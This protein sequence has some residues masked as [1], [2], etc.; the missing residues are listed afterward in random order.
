MKSTLLVRDVMTIGVPIC[1]EGE[2]CGAV[3]ARLES[4]TRGVSAKRT[5]GVCEVVVV[6]DEDGMACG[7]LTRERLGEQEAAAP[8]GEVMDEDIPTV[9]PNIPVEAAARLMRDRG[10]EH[11]FLMHDWPGEPRPSAMISLRTIERVSH[12]SI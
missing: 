9:P 1:H 10:V 6:L 4:Q 12:E 11:L 7:W 8:V 2:T 3:L 5:P